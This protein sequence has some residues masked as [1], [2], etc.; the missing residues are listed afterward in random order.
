MVNR[1]QALLVP[2]EVS[3]VP[4]DALLMAKRRPTDDH[5]SGTGPRYILR[6]LHP[7]RGG[8]ACLRWL[9]FGRAAADVLPLAFNREINLVSDGVVF[10][11]SLLLGKPMC[12][13]HLFF[14]CR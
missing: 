12:C 8:S 6:Q 2:F 11:F 5:R 14:G 4:N 7:I 13:V 9:F 10:T 1:K 3:L